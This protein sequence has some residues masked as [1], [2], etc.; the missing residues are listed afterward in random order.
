[1]TA[2]QVKGFIAKRISVTAITGGSTRLK[3]DVKEESIQRRAVAAGPAGGRV[4][5]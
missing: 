2:R 1:V 4:H 5:G 3:N